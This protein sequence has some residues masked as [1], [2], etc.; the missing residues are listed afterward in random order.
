MNELKDRI[1]P[2][3]RLIHWEP[4]PQIRSSMFAV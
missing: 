2:Y 4:Q 3:P 1:H